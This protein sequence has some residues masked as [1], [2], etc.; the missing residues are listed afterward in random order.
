MARHGRGVKVAKQSLIEPAMQ[1]KSTSS[2]TQ[3]RIYGGH[4][5]PFALWIAVILLTQGLEYT[6]LLP[7]AWYPWSYA[8]KSVVC[9][10]LF[11]WLKPWRVYPCPTLRALP[12]ALFVGIAVAVCWILPETAWLQGVAPRVQLFYHRWLILMPGSLPKYF[13]PTLFPALPPHHPAWAYAPVVAGWPL[14]VAK[15][16]GSAGVIAVVEEFFFRGFFYRWLQGAKFWQVPLHQFDGTAFIT[17]AL[18]FAFEHDRW[19]MG[20]VAGLAYGWLALRHGIWS[21]VGAH[22]LT[23]LLLGVYVI[24]SKQYGFW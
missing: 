19:L 6:L 16:I 22:V 23:N 5:L 21:A 17:V 14:T 3:G 1:Q 24:Q 8:V 18:V 13:D 15:L 10:L 4:V 12:G 2:A 7:R 20:L 11:I 9:A